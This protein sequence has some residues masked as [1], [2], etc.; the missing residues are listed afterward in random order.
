MK[1]EFPYFLVLDVLLDVICF[2][3]L[4]KCLLERLDFKELKELKES[5]LLYDCF[6]PL[7]R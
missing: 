5:P 1:I 6:T 2:F 4:K 3:P 7:K